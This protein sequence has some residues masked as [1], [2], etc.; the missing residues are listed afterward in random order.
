VDSI[1]QKDA[2]PIFLAFF[3][4]GFIMKKVYG[5]FVACD[6]GDWQKL[7]PEVV[8]FSALHYTVFGWI[9]WITKDLSSSWA[10]V[11]L[12]VLVLPVVWA[13]AQLLLRDW[14]KWAPRLFSKKILTFMLT[15]EQTPWDRLFDDQRDRWLIAKTKTGDF[16]GGYMGKGSLTSTYPSA[17]QIYITQ[18]WRCNGAGFL[19]DGAIA[20]GLLI[21]G[22]EVEYIHLF[23]PVKRQTNER[24]RL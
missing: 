19:G 5:L 8:A 7:L 1:W 14:E 9:I 22:D 18:P 21:R 17:D 24:Q 6:N 16:V 11:G 15:P 23:E 4:P 20:N 3:I 10:F 2:L 13:P 12:V